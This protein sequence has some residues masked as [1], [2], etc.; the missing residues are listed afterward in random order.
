MANVNVF[1]SIEN[2]FWLC[3]LQSNS[4]NLT[5]FSIS[6]LAVLLKLVQNALPT[7]WKTVHLQLVFYGES[8][9]RNFES[10]VFACSIARATWF[11]CSIKVWFV[12]TSINNILV[13]TNYFKHDFNNF[14]PIV[15]TKGVLFLALFWLFGFFRNKAVFE[16][17]PILPKE[18]VEYGIWWIY[19][20]RG[21]LVAEVNLK[22]DASLLWRDYGIV[23]GERGFFWLQALTL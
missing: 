18:M 7:A 13:I 11:A 1:I 9:S 5:T 12:A 4:W 6:P 15:L 19:T 17:W 10:F 22:N 2:K 20:C 8:K 21:M 16:R 14:L 23:S 3:C